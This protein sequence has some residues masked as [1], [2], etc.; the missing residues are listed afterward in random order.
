MRNPELTSPRQ[1]E[2]FGREEV[3]ILPE[4]LALESILAERCEGKNL[5]QTKYGLSKVRL[6]KDNRE[7]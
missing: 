2:E 3:T 1:L 7:S 5:S 6:A 4:S